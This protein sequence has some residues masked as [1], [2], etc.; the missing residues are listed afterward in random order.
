M[1]CEICFAPRGLTCN[2]GVKYGNTSRTPVKNKIDIADSGAVSPIELRD[3][4]RET[5]EEL[6]PNEEPD[7][8]HENDS[9]PALKAQASV[10]HFR[11][12]ARLGIP[13]ARGKLP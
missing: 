12:G 1:P 2:N 10:S 9:Q 13:I 7:P 11:A 3:L 4:K 8:H 6:N 5:D